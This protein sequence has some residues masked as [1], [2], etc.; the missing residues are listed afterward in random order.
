MARLPKDGEYNWGVVLEEYLKQSLDHTGQ[1]HSGPINPHTGQPNANLADSVKAGLIRLAGDLSHSAANPKVTGIQGMPVSSKVP[2]HGQ[3]LAWNA[4][5]GAWEPT[6][7]TDSN[8]TFAQSMAINS[9][10]I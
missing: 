6:S 8:P 10:R 3:V 7:N 1:L 9:M 4:S 5:I 2:Q